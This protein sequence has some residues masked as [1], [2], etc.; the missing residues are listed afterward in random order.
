M[1]SNRTK[2]S[3]RAPMRIEQRK[4]DLYDEKCTDWTGN[5]TIDKKGNEHMKYTRSPFNPVPLPHSHLRPSI[6][7]YRG[8]KTQ[9]YWR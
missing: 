3:G 1:A 5:V 2:P 6:S 4:R 9:L 7:A 8:V